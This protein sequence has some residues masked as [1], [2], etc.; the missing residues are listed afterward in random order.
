MSKLL[1][2]TQ[3]GLQKWS[4]V[5]RPLQIFLIRGVCILVIWKLL[6]LLLLK[7]LHIPDTQ[8]TYAIAQITTSFFKLISPQLHPQLL[9]KADMLITA[10]INGKLT[11]TIS[12]ADACNG[13]E[14]MVLHLG[15]VFSL[16]YLLRKQLTYALIGIFLIVIA[17][18]SRCLTLI[19]V[20]ISYPNFFIFAHHYLFTLFI[21]LIVFFIW[22]SLTQQWIIYERKK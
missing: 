11:E 4:Q 22:K 12:I 6:Y 3:K 20:Y 1:G 21:Y 17:N 15:F 9:P 19:Y 5:P 8:L 10:I 16:P 18:V 2:N 13:L 7:P 14:L